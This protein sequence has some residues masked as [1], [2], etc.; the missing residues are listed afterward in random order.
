[1]SLPRL[2]VY[3]NVLSSQDLA[4]WRG[5]LTG[6]AGLDSQNVSICGESE[7]EGELLT[8]IRERVGDLPLIHCILFALHDNHDTEVHTDIGEY[9]VLLFPYDCPDGSA[10][11]GTKD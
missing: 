11:T 4:V 6:V 3:D 1:M 2:K 8:W 10:G 5:K 7:V 9:V